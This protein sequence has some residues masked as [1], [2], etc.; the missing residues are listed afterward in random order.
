M[1]I[2]KAGAEEKSACIQLATLHS[3]DLEAELDLI[4]VNKSWG[5]VPKR[6]QH[7]APVFLLLID[8]LLKVGHNRTGSIMSS[9]LDLA[10]VL[11][12]EKSGPSVRSRVFLRGIAARVEVTVNEAASSGLARS[13]Q[14]VLYQRVSILP[15]M[16]PQ[17]GWTADYFQ[18]K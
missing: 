14:K 3:V 11:N 17:S 1:T 7:Q 2:S 13:R 18:I 5:L 16:G 10:R 15:G 12:K 8:Y 9:H 6:P 4:V